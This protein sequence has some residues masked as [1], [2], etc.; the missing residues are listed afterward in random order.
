MLLFLM[1]SRSYAERSRLMA[2]ERTALLFF[3]DGC[4]LSETE[5]CVRLGVPERTFYNYFPTKTDA[6]RPLLERGI[7]QIAEIVRDAA[8]SRPFI[9]VMV[10][11][12]EASLWG[13]EGEYTRR[14]M[15]PVRG[16][17]APRQGEGRLPGDDHDHPNRSRPQPVLDSNAI[18]KAGRSFAAAGSVNHSVPWRRSDAARCQ[19][20]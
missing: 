9:E 13:E 18:P 1:P 6:L 8:P 5:I 15:P 4:D 19:L 10:L 2:S 12:F 14:I 17:F 11:G 20:R 7:R 16:W 3:T